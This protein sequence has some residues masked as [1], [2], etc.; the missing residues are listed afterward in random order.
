[1]EGKIE[2]VGKV[3]R[4][5]GRVSGIVRENDDRSRGIRGRGSR[6]GKNESMRNKG[7]S[8]SCGEK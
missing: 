4:S 5:E 2:E 8:M 6:S 7:R 1:M 3:K